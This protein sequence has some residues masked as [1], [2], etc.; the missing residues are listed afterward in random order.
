MQI[1]YWQ[2]FEMDVFHLSPSISNIQTSIMDGHDSESMMNVAKTLF[3]NPAVFAV[4]KM[5]GQKWKVETS[6]IQDSPVFL[7][8]ESNKSLNTR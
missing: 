6:Q 3:S 5:D 8:C 7:G 2:V 4:L 1:E